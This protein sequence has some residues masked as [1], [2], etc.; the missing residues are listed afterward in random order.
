MR[1]REALRSA[2]QKP[3]RNLRVPLQTRFPATE[4]RSIMSKE[5]WAISL[6]KVYPPREHEFVSEICRQWLICYWEAG[7]TS[8]FLSHL[9]YCPRNATLYPD[10]SEEH[11]CSDDLQFPRSAL[12]LDFLNRINPTW[13]LFGCI[14]QNL[15]ILV[16]IDL[17]LRYHSSAYKV[18]TTSTTREIKWLTVLKRIEWG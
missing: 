18:R 11:D 9:K 4:R 8:L 7:E 10:D 6:E 13:F 2:L 3:T 16:P 5:R 12:R 15:V 14:I 1:D 17:A